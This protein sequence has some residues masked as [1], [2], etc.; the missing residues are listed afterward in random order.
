LFGVSLFG[1]G[2]WNFLRYLP[3]QMKEWLRLA[4]SPSVVKRAL[5]YAIVVGLILITINH[6]DAI[7]RGELSRTRILKMALTVLVPYIVSTLSSVGAM[8]EKRT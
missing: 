3:A 6:G 1:V 7:L 5:G 4:S 2:I 8:R